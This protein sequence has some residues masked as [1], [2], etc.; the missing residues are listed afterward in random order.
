MTTPPRSKR[1]HE[2]LDRLPSRQLDAHT[3]EPL[4]RTIK[5]VT[6]TRPEDLAVLAVGTQLLRRLASSGQT[7]LFPSAIDS[8]A[9]RVSDLLT[10]G[11]NMHCEVEA[12]EL[13]DWLLGPELGEA[14]GPQA[15]QVQGQSVLYDPAAP[16]I[17]ILEAAIAQ[18]FDVWIDY[19][20]KKRGEMNTRRVSPREIEAETWLRGF[21]HTRRTER[22][23]RLTRITRCVPVGGR[24]LRTAPLTEAPGEA[25]GPSP[26]Q[27]SLLDD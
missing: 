8:L 4:V 9:D 24:P 25:P 1:L 15:V 27:Q 16:P 7:Q 17:A 3:R 26:V 22:H 14:P 2:R 13:I 6:L 5:P 12:Y 10:P 23:F 11:E 19:F 21:C 18:R 20:S